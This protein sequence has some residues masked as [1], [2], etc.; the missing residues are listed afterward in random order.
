MELA[1]DVRSDD[2]SRREWTSVKDDVDTVSAWLAARF[3]AESSRDGFDDLGSV[4]LYALLACELLAGSESNLGWCAL[5]AEESDQH[6]GQPLVRVGA[7]PPLDRAW[8][9]A[10]PQGGSSGPGRRGEV[11]DDEPGVA[12]LGQVLADGIVVEAEVRGQ[13]SDPYWPCGFVEVAEDCVS[14]WVREGASL[15]RQPVAVLGSSRPCC[16]R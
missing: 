10:V 9:G 7:V 8:G 4:H 14:R 11:F 6:G 3:E 2:G 13:L 16:H 15:D 5:S 1:D 12:Q